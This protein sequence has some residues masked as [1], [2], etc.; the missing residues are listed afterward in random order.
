MLLPGPNHSALC[1]CLRIP[2]CLRRYVCVCV[3]LPSPAMPPDFRRCPP[4]RPFLSPALTDAVQAHAVHTAFLPA[5]GGPS[6]VD[7][8]G[9]GRD[10][11]A[12]RPPLP[13]SWQHA[14]PRPGG[15]AVAASWV[16]HPQRLRRGRV[17]AAAAYASCSEGRTNGDGVRSGPGSGPKSPDSQPMPGRA[18]AAAAATCCCERHGTP[19]GHAVHGA[20]AAV[21]R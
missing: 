6:V 17:R 18:R 12:A 8:A 19:E 16:R 14:R 21:T 7:R 1:D 3:G 5:H 2:A 11:P 13:R 4:S 20:V 10:A 15:G 9:E